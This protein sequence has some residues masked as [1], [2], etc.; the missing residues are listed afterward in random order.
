MIP[1]T[2][3]DTMAR[4]SNPQPQVSAQPLGPT[5]YPQGMQ[6]GKSSFDGL[7]TN[8]AD[9]RRAKEALQGQF[10]QKIL[11]SIGNTQPMNMQSLM[12]KLKQGLLGQQNKPLPTLGNYEP[13]FGAR[14]NGIKAGSMFSDDTGGMTV[15]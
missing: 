7:M 12:D 8:S 11:G 9:E 4:W 15:L 5:G 1:D 13:A 14:G 10:Q 6:E 2:M 3:Q